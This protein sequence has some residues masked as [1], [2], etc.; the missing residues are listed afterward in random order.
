MAPRGQLTKEENNHP[1]P[2]PELP[3]ADQNNTERDHHNPELIDGDGRNDHHLELHKDGEEY[4][5]DGDGFKNR[6]GFVAHIYWFN[7]KT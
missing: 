1:S 2:E 3:G 5:D 7:C 6:P 4:K